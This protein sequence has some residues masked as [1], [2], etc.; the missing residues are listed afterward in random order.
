MSHAPTATPRLR[1]TQEE[2]SAETRTR[3]LEATIESLI[4]VGYASTTTTGV[5]ERAGVSRGA[6]VH[7]FPRK[8]DLVVAAVAHLAAKNVHVLRERAAA[9]L[10]S[11][12]GDSLR[13]SES[14]PFDRLGAVIGLVAETFAGPL[15][16]AALE[17]WIAA[18]T[19]AELHAALIP[20]ERV[21]G[22]G[23]VEL[24][25]DVAGD[26]A[27]HPDFDAVLEL[28]LHLARGMAL[29]KILRSDDTARRR[30][31]DVWRHLAAHALQR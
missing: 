16:T 30:S 11:A 7:H 15:F 25:R 31:L 26:L 10:S 14:A 20:F 2:R 12:N 24:W 13:P 18:R 22:R 29:Q 1:R 5:C 19:D 17:L 3:L 21:A 9:L 28:T 23:L 27:D 4:E 6:Q 8:Q